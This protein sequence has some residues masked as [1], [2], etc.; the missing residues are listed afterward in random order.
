[1]WK[2]TVLY[3][4]FG[5]I[6]A[7][8]KLALGRDLIAHADEG[9]RLAPAG[10]DAPY[11]GVGRILRIHGVRQLVRRL[12]LLRADVGSSTRSGAA[13]DSSPYSRSCRVYGCR[14]IC[15]RR[16]REREFPRSAQ[17]RGQ[18]DDRRRHRGDA[19][20][21]PDA[22]RPSVLEI[23][24]DSAEHAGH[25]GAAGGRRALF[26]A[27][28]CQRCSRVCRGS[29]RHQRVLR[30]VADLLPHPV[31]ALSI[32]AL[33]PDEFPSQPQRTHYR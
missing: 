29:Q 14:G 6:L 2:P 19:A 26:A 28:S 20:R 33:A 30:E 8:G 22:P 23:H 13:S 18:F 11:V 7:V 21:A 17:R 27:R 15:P 12:S 31:H 10:L 16:P 4:L 3:G 1:M 5:A 32:K 25:A 24:D 9:R